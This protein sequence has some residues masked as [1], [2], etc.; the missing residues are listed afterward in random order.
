MSNQEDQLRYPIG[1]FTPSESYTP[2]EI[3]ENIKRIEALP[4][5]LESIFRSFSSRQLETP[6]REGGW[7]ARQVLHHLADSHMNAYIRIKWTLTEATPMIKAYDEKRWAETPEIEIDPMI[8]IELLKT[9]HTKF[10]ALLS[11]IKA[12]DQKKE[13]QH[14]ET[15]KNVSIE[16]MIALYAWHGEHHLGH[17]NIIAAKPK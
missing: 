6:Y 17:L 15:K 11:R 16:R 7:T 9:L 8:S 3:S 12:Q 10:V 13:F 1:K 14:P 4:A 5:K 2:Q